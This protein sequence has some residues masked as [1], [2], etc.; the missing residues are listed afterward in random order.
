M[1]DLTNFLIKH[2]VKDN[3]NISNVK[4]REAYGKLSGVVG[5]ACN[6]LL[7][8]A[9]FGVG[10]IFNSISVM[11]DAANNLSDA[12]SS[13]VTLI[14]FKMSGKPADEEHPYG[15]ERIEYVS[16]LVVSFIIL[17]IGIELIKTSLAK[18]F[19]PSAS[20]VGAI[21]FAV[22]ILSV[23][24]KL[25][26]FAFNKHIGKKIDSTVISATAQDSLNDAIA[27]SAVL[28][29]AVIT[30][31]SGFNLDGYMG[32]LVGVYIIYAGINLIKDTVD[33]LLGMAPSA[34]LT[35][36]I[37]TKVL[38][39]KGVE[40]IHDLIIHN[41]GPKRCF[42]SVHVEVSAKQDILVSHDIADNIE[43]DFKMDMGIDL[44]VHLDPLIKDDETL[45]AARN[46]LVEILADIDTGISH[47]D[48]RMVKGTTHSN[49]IF[50]ICVPV[51]FHISDSE[52]ID[53]IINAVH[54]RE[55]TYECVITIDK[56]YCSTISVSD[57]Q[58]NKTE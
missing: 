8:A 33:P 15:H 7:S 53:M 39:Y 16:G 55:R 19:A 27:T 44:V 40:G 1:N 29:S 47:H 23:C 5:I 32:V 30:C 50:D 34:E 46:M 56:N 14:G 35:D 58:D 43:R 3:Q 4:V 49:L 54:L 13:V 42:A 11:A 26:M 36:K 48:F 20:Q 22:L 18:V 45:N 28:L 12:M 21:T 37:I 9:K 51:N 38:S 57:K 24:V 6:V 41:Y 10:F 2:F 17:F 52:L 25:W 31:F